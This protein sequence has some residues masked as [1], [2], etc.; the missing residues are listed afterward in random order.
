V[1]NAVEPPGVDGASK[2]AKPAAVGAVG[3]FGVA[4]AP[5]SSDDEASAS[6]RTCG[7]Y[8][9]G[10]ESLGGLTVAV[11]SRP[12]AMAVVIVVAVSAIAYFLPEWTTSGHG[13]AISVVHSGYKS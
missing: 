3:L 12:V 7:V 10:G 2:G 8:A 11:A 5:S 13:D 9:G 1:L 4:D 6:G